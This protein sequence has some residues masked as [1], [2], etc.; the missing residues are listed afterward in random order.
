MNYE[1]IVV[2]RSDTG[3]IYILRDILYIPQLGINILST[4]P[5]SD[6]IST[7]YKDR[8]YIYTKDIYNNPNIYKPNQLGLSSLSSLSS[9]SRANSP[10]LSTISS[11]IAIFTATKQDRL[12]KTKT[13]IL[14]P[15]G[16]E[17]NLAIL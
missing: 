4:N 6:M 5:L 15:K 12:Y 3:Y 8:A 17:R 10:N 2:I 14:Y 7:F 1:G 11:R 16:L 13:D 9:L